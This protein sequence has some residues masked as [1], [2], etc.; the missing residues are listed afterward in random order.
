MSSR[1]L[2]IILVRLYWNLNFLDFFE[3]T[4]QISNFMTIRP[5]GAELFHVDTRGRTD[6]QTEL[7]NLVVA[8]CNFANEPK[9]EF[10]LVYIL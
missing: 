2:R 6:G 1:K 10:T 5:V 9:M 7:S 8:F 4:T 3:K